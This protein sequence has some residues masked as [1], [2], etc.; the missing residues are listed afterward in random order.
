MR[1]GDA[2]LRPVDDG[3]PYDLVRDDAGRPVAW[4][5]DGE[6]LPV[7]AIA[8]DES[9]RDALS[10]LLAS[11]VRYGA[12]LDDDGRVDGV[13]AIDAI[14]R[15]LA[16]RREGPARERLTVIAQACG[17]FFATA[18][19]RRLRGAKT[20][21]ARAGSPTTS[22]ATRRRS[23]RLVVVRLGGRGFAIA[24]TLALMTHRRRW[25]VGPF[26][27]FTG[28]LY[29]I[30]SLAA[31]FLLL[32]ITGRGSR[33]DHRADRVHAA[34]PVPQRRRRPRPLPDEARDAGRGMGLTARQLLWRVELPLGVPAIMAGLRVAT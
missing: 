20:A 27:Q 17:G 31:F 11:P 18:R 9:L 5:R 15:L 16:A 2:D 7:L 6:R 24:F 23:A 19:A 12:V 13:L 26:V 10:A 29:T 25:L 22:T 28:I 34:D 33:P 14:H 30:P 3:L 4:Q 8:R 32:P 1:A 21:C